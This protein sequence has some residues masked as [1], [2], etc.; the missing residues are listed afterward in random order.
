MPVFMCTHVLVARALEEFKGSEGKEEEHARGPHCQLAGLAR[1][2]RQ[3]FV[4]M[5]QEWPQH[6][7][8]AAM[9]HPLR[10][11]LRWS[12]HTLTATHVTYGNMQLDQE[13]VASGYKEAVWSPRN[14]SNMCK[15]SCCAR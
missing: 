1:S 5:G 9:A 4:P 7:H 10:P 13:R 2:C 12:P 11:E 3:R 8:A 6:G 14:D 15:G